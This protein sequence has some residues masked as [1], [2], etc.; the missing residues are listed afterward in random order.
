MKRQR[1]Q[2]RAVRTSVAAGRRA[3]YFAVLLHAWP[4]GLAKTQAQFDPLGCQVSGVIRDRQRPKT[5]TGHA[6]RRS[7]YGSNGRKW[8]PKRHCAEVRFRRLAEA[9][10]RIAR[11]PVLP[12]FGSLPGSGSLSLRHCPGPAVRATSAASL[13]CRLSPSTIR[14]GGVLLACKQRRLAAIVTADVVGYSHAPMSRSTI[15]R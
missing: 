11:L 8:K 5:C 1:R 14:V 10:L 15:R 12:L 13:P 2:K 6:V 9:R 7:V 4:R 3:R